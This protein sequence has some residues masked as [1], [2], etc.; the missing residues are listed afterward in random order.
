MKTPVCGTC[1]MTSSLCVACQKKMKEGSI[2]KL[3]VEVAQILYKI[4]ER[5]N[6]SD[7]SF[8]KAVDLGRVVLITTDGNVGLLIGRGGSV[9]SQI[10]A[11]LNKQVRIVEHSADIRKSISDMITPAKLLGINTVWHDG[12]EKLKIRLHNKDAH[13]LP[14]DAQTLEGVIKGWL[15]KEAIITFE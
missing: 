7:A 11:A 9:V 8:V 5:H 12:R 3:D 4:N 14:I 15:G 1:V 10:S 6:I 2:S 13:H